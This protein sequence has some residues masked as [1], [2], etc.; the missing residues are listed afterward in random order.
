MINNVLL[1]NRIEPKTRKILRKNQND[2][3]RNRSTTSQ[4]LTIR[5]ILG[6]CSKNLDATILF[7][8]FFKAFNSIHRGKMEQILLA[9][10]LPKE[11]IVAIMMLYE[12]TKVKVRSPDGDSDYF[13]IVA[14]VLQGDTLAPYVFIICLDYVLRTSINIMKDNGFKL[15]KERNRRY[16]AQTIT[17]ADYADD[18]ALLAN[19][20]AQAEILLQS[21]EGA[22]AGIG[23]NVNADK[24]QY[25]C[26]NQ[27]GD[28]SRLNG[29]S[30]KVVD[31]FTYQGSSVLSKDK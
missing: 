17:D 26:F 30:L 9:Y 10:G 3:R 13:D 8:D 25:M 11:T 24:T 7:V 21:L 2:F 19:T 15:A 20:S 22:A 18:K 29:S 4:I 28:I 27:T 12:N 1:R 14:V 6:V 5:R 16:P 23:L 31:K